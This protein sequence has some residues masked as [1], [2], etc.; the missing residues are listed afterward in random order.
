MERIIG[1]YKSSGPTSHDV[2]NRLRKIT[3]I[4][5]IGHA[6]TLDPMAEGVL[7]VGLGREG[8]KRLSTLVTKEKEYAA[9]IKL[10]ENSST[11]DSE[12]E[13]TKSIVRGKPSEK[14]VGE[15]VRAFLG[16]IQQVP[17]VYS[18]IKINGQPAHR[19]IRR[20]QSVEMQPRTVKLY[21]VEL[22][23][24]SWPFVKVRLV[25]S[26]GFYVRAF[27][28]DLGQKLGTGGHLVGLVRTRVGN[29]ESRQA[30]RPEEYQNYFSQYAPN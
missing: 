13:K 23:E 6:G 20:G 2:I 11:D 4:R 16:E 3:G 24:Y 8:T 25:T 28:R 14:E 18:A 5:K 27:A 9:T 10:G 29:F 19:R 21:Q 22:R 7:V 26:S 1:V 17:P 30:V 15:A 12:G